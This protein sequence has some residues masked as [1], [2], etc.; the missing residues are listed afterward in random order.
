VTVPQGFGFKAQLDG[1]PKPADFETSAAVTAYP[2]LS[3]FHL[4]RPRYTPSIVNGTTTFVVGGAAD[5]VSLKAGD[6]IMVGVAR[7]DD[8]SLDHSQISSSIRPGVVRHALCDDQ[9]RHHLPRLVHDPAGDFATM[10]RRRRRSADRPCTVRAASLPTT[11]RS[12]SAMRALCRPGRAV[13]ELARRHPR[14]LPLPS[15]ALR[16]NVLR[17]L[18]RRPHWT[19]LDGDAVRNCRESARARCCRQ[20][21]LEQPRRARWCCG[22][23]ALVCFSLVLFGSPRRLRVI[24]RGSAATGRWPGARGAST[25]LTLDSAGLSRGTAS[26]AD[27]RNITFHQVEGDAFA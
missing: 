17:Q 9:G 20:C 13:A 24:E 14:R 10:F 26:T 7:A 25:V 12:R 21:P 4:Y 18:A 15:A 3:E 6:K 27:I 23:P 8:G 16:P 5:A 22:R 19:W 2:G 1:A 11:A